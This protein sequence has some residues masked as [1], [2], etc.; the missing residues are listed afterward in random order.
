VRR[1]KIIKLL[2]KLDMPVS[3]IR[4]VFEGKLSLSDAAAR[5]GVTLG[6]QIRNLTKA[7]SITEQLAS[8][9]GSLQTLDEEAWLRRL[10]EMEGEGVSFMNIQN[11]DTRKKFTGAVVACTCMIAVFALGIALL[12]WVQSVDPMPLG[13][14]IA[15][16]AVSGGCIICTAAAFISRYREIKGGEEN[17]LGNY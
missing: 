1:L 5:H 9:T 15:L 12:L 11:Q 7:K 10:E 4:D 16:I 13:L 8:E 14:F 2:R 17:D 6:G 3:E